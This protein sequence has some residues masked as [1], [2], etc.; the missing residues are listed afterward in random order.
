MEKS[1][2]RPTGDVERVLRVHGNLLFRTSLIM[3]KNA[4]D[5]EDVVQE[6]LI[7]YMKKAPE[8][9]NEEHEKAW[10]LTVATNKCRDMLRFQTRHPITD[11]EQMK[12]F[13]ESDTSDT[14]DS[15]IL[16]ALM[17]LPEK[18]RIVLLLYYVEE[19]RMEEIAQIIG[20]S[21]SAVKMRLQKGRR[22]LEDAYRK[23]Y[24]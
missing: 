5:A 18:F 12:E 24:L 22:L 20:K 2:V 14:K 19:Y 21:T 8:F 3:L 17:T 7:S 15:G 23:E 10:L 6:T 1:S 13:M 4:T 9:E 16:E 11:M